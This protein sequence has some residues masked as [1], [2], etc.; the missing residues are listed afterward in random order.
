MPLSLPPP[1]PSLHP[2][3]PIH[4]SHVDVLASLTGAGWGGCAVALVPE[5]TVGT[6]LTALQTD[7]FSKRVRA[8]FHFSCVLA[9]QNR[10]QDARTC[11]P[12]R[13]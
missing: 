4:P 2:I 1:P 8:A 7:F 9:Q 12:D 11:L 6:F 5:A 13:P 3:T 10:R